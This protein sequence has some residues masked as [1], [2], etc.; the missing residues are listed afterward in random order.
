[1][2]YGIWYMVYGIWHMV[3]GVCLIWF[4]INSNR[5]H[6]IATYSI[7][8]EYPQVLSKLSQ[9]LLSSVSELVTLL[10]F[11][12]RWVGNLLNI[13]MIYPKIYHEWYIIPDDYI[14]CAFIEKFN[15]RRDIIPAR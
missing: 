9:L 13:S 14:I 10:D 11:G 12:L 5:H 7:M 6:N 3:Y 15:S 8:L 2:V 4:R 1:M